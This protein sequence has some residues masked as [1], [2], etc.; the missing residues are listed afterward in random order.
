MVT[1]SLAI[2]QIWHEQEDRE[3]QSFSLFQISDVEQTCHVCVVLI[4]KP[5]LCLSALTS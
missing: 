5:E 4:C 1:S 3:K 2:Q